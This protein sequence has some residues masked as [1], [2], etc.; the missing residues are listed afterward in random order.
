MRDVNDEIEKLGAGLIVIGS[1]R[2]DQAREFRKELS[3]ETPVYADPHMKAYRAAGLRRDVRS[4]IN[5]KTLI[6][7]VRALRNGFRQSKVKGDPWQQGGV[8]VIKP[9]NKILF[10]YASQ[11]AGDH[12]KVQSILEALGGAAG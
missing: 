6:H 3:L 9:E 4:T 8:L 2:P 7:G 11:N 10:E 5:P 1:G 12:P